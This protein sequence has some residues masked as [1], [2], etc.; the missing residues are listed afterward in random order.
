MSERDD[1]GPGDSDEVTSAE[2]WQAPRMFPLSYPGTAPAHHYLL[3]NGRVHRMVLPDGNVLGAVL[4]DGRKVDD[5]LGHAGLLSL[6]E[7]VPVLAYGANRNPHTLALKFDHHD[8]D[9]D[10]DAVAVPVLT[11]RLSGFD[12]VAAGLSPQGCLYADLTPS[13]GT[14]VEVHLTLLDV[15]QA[16]AIHESEGVGWNVYDCARVPDFHVDGT[17]LTISPLAYAGCHPVFIP[18]GTTEPIAFSMIAADGRTFPALEQIDLLGRLIDTA[19]L[20]GGLAAQ[21]GIPDESSPAVIA[22]EVARHLSGAWWYQH[23]TGDQPTAASLRIQEQIWQALVDHAAP[24]STSDLMRDQGLVLDAEAAYA[25][26][27]ELRLSAQ[28]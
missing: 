24:R 21:L 8:Y 23:N 16:R 19:E 25:S 6:A 28:L 26:G 13:P 18:P 12:V 4:D 20:A 10:G 11:G 5:V 2:S 17:D 7:R 22:H 27:E 15:D 1:R 14:T 3:L 9:H